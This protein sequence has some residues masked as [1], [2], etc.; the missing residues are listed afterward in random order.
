MTSAVATTAGVVLERT[1]PLP[2]GVMVTKRA[3]GDVWSYPNIHGD[4]QATANTAG[5][6]QGVTLT[7]D[8]YGATIAGNVDNMA[9]G[10]DNGWLGQHQR[11]L[12]HTTGLNPVIEMGA[13]PYNPVLGRFTR[14]DP[15][16]GG[17]CN[18]YDYT[19]ADPIGSVDLTGLWCG[20]KCLAKKVAAATKRAADAAAQKLR[21]AASALGS[22]KVSVGVCP[23]VGC[24]DLSFQNGRIGANASVGVAYAMPSASISVPGPDTRTNGCDANRDVYLF[25]NTPMGTVAHGGGPAGSPITGGTSTFTPAWN[26]AS[27]SS[28]YGTGGGLIGGSAGCSWGF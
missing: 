25:L 6:K 24:A 17:S 28:G 10:I 1:I 19:C 22:V 20:P 4:V 18:D 21:G 8:P 27:R 7:Y 23:L 16:D 14:V 26:G 2:G 13:R 3:T 11:P 9:G 12:E 5:V 15:V